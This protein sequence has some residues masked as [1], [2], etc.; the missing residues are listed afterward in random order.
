MYCAPNVSSFMVIHVVTA[1]ETLGFSNSYI[2]FGFFLSAPTEYHSLFQYGFANLFNFTIMF[3]F[4]HLIKLTLLI[5]LLAMISAFSNSTYLDRTCVR[6]GSVQPGVTIR[7]DRT[8]PR[9]DCLGLEF[10]G[11]DQSAHACNFYI[12]S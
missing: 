10:P 12:V 2:L 1:H 6:L 11:L 3:S 4:L 7:C 8:N 9:T 5:I